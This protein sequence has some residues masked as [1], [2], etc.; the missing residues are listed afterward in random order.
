MSESPTYTHAR[1]H[2]HVHVHTH[3]APTS[4]PWHHVF[5][6]K[7]FTDIYSAKWLAMTG[8]SPHVHATRAS[9]ASLLPSLNAKN[10][11]LLYILHRWTVSAEHALSRINHR[12]SHLVKTTWAQF[13]WIVFKQKMCK[14]LYKKLKIISWYEP[15]NEECTVSTVIFRFMPLESTTTIDNCR[16][17][18]HYIPN[19]PTL[20]IFAR[21]Y[22]VTRITGI[23]P[24]CQDWPNLGSDVISSRVGWGPGSLSPHSMVL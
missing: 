20:D 2:T 17:H 14:N 11:F 3:A 13:T 12:I 15:L 10:T 1:T 24:V 21:I 7:I 18:F 16:Q 23:H 9:C 5:K 4:L 6:R 19:A 22:I 8:F